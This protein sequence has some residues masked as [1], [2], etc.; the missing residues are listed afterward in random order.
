[1]GFVKTDPK[2]M[3]SILKTSFIPIVQ[4]PK[5]FEAAYPIKRNGKYF[6]MYSSGDCRL[7]SYA[8]HYSVSDNPEDS[9]TPGKNSSIQVTNS[10]G[11]IDGSSHH[12]VI[13]EGND[14]YIVY[15]RHDNPHSTNSEF[16]QVCVDKL[17]FSDSVTRE[18]VV[19][20]HEGVG[21][22]RKNKITTTYLA[23]KAKVSA[24]S[25]HHLVS[26]PTAYSHTS[27]EYSYLPSFSEGWRH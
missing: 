12:S 25:Y 1:M 20:T 4:T 9:F 2:D 14:Y 19:P 3:H 27:Y 26:N 6:L 18:K 13:K 23:S 22:L 7:R 15:H 21:L 10:D 8:V 11:T 24:S 5:A 16:R 17:I